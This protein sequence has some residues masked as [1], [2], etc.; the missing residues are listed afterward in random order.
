MEGRVSSW[1][2]VGVR[3]V[4]APPHHSVAVVVA[5][6]AEVVAAAAVVAVVAVAAAETDAPDGPAGADAAEV[7]SGWTDA[8]PGGS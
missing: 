5:V 2:W 1:M 4:G 6:V 7:P 3:G 8:A